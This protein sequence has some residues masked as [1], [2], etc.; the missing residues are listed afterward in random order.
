MRGDLCAALILCGLCSAQSALAQNYPV[1]SIR[2]VVASSPGGSSDVLA[3]LVA[4]KLGEALGQQIVVENRA[5]AS[6]IIG[7]E[8][9]A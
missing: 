1:R 5:G 6:G 4:P 7:V 3:R 9:V 2:M 8:V